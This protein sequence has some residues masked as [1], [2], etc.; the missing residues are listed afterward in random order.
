MTFF[1]KKKKIETTTLT[2]YKLIFKTVDG[3]T[4]EFNKLKYIDET[5]I[6]CSALEFFLIDKKFLSDDDEIQYPIQNI[7]SIKFE[8]MAEKENVI[9]V[10][11][12]DTFYFPQIWYNEEDIK[13]L[14]NS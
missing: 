7:L 3:K 4:H 10:S 14:K 9:R 1:N 12:D 11:R 8:K 2:K 6:I 13:I 5:T